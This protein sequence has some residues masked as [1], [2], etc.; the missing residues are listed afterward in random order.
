MGKKD[1]DDTLDEYQKLKNEIIIEKVNEVFR[2]QPKNYVAALNELGFEYCEDDEDDE[3]MEE[4][5]ARP[6]NKNQR[7]L[8]AFFEGEQDA[9]E[10][11]LATFLAERNAEHPNFPLIRKYFKN[12][13]RKLK[14]LLLYGLDLYATRIDLLSDLAYFHEFENILSILIAN[15]TR[16]CVEEKDLEKFTELAQDFYDATNPDGYE[17][18]FAL[19]EIFE[20][21]TEQRKII[22]FLIAE[23]EEAG[24]SMMPIKF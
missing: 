21:H 12:A 3:E 1:K 4:K 16:A 23:E 17:A 7:D 5:N 9:S 2:S 6:E 18:L 11:I 15:Y 24:K 19:Q 14:V 22:D 8:I 20:P 13:N 10:M